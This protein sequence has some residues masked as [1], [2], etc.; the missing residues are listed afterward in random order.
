M[1]GR[2]LIIEDDLS[3]QRFMTMA[4]SNEGFE[5][6]IAANGVEAL[7]LLSTFQPNLIF[8][9]WLMPRMNGQEFLNQ[10]YALPGPRSSVIVLSAST[11]I[12][13]LAATVLADGFLA[14]PFNLNTLLA[15]VEQHMTNAV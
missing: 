12:D 8:V 11:N 13:K 5:I 7:A 4:L 15:I 9:D 2:I 6:A 10:Y 14:K 1:A 3:I